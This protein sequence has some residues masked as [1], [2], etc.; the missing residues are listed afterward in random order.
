MILCQ[1]LYESGFN[2]VVL[3]PNEILK[4]QQVDDWNNRAE[5]NNNFSFLGF[6]GPLITLMTYDEWFLHGKALTPDGVILID[7]VHLFIEMDTKYIV[8]TPCCPYLSIKGKTRVIGTSASIG[9]EKG[10]G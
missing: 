8:T 5:L 7:E 9:T 4:Q 6:L 3:F 1:Y 10:K 2:V